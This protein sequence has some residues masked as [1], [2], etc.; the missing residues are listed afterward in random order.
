MRFSQP[1]EVAG[2][3]RGTDNPDVPR[4]S[5]T[6]FLGLTEARGSNHASRRRE[7][8][9]D[10]IAYSPTRPLPRTGRGSCSADSEPRHAARDE[11]PTDQ[12]PLC[13]DEQRTAAT[14]TVTSPRSR[15]P[16]QLVK[17]AV[18]QHRPVLA[19]RPSDSLH[20]AG[21]CRPPPATPMASRCTVSRRP[22]LA[23]P[24]VARRGV[25]L[26]LPAQ[27]CANWAGPRS[28]PTPACP[29]GRAPRDP[30]G[31]PALGQGTQER[32]LRPRRAGLLV[33]RIR[34][35][36]AH[37]HGAIPHPNLGTGQGLWRIKA[38]LLRRTAPDASRRTRTLRHDRTDD[39]D[40]FVVRVNIDGFAGNLSM[41]RA[42]G[43]VGALRLPRT[44]SRPR[45]RADL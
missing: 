11:D 12:R 1:H 34:R 37:R 40:Q 30:T 28:S 19:A 31:Q 44:W 32:A 3:I 29:T 35:A 20:A 36:R 23:T 41:C 6:L 26:G 9:R 38:P 17:L 33:S 14:G 10:P 5:V 27:G 18:D 2:N 8:R 7:R 24:A 42:V 21:E 13:L 16:A 43:V 15:E 4:A 45:R 25:D 22:L 39:R